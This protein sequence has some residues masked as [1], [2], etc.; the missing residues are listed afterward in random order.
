[1]AIWQVCLVWSLK[2]SGDPSEGSTG[3]RHEDCPYVSCCGGFSEVWIKL[4]HVSL[5]GW[6][7]KAGLVLKDSSQRVGEKL[8]MLKVW[9]VAKY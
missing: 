5:C 4:S 1:M 2:V 3:S 7:E 9:R 6:G 8:E